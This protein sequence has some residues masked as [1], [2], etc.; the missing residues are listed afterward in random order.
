MSHDINKI[1]R[2]ITED[3][4]IMN[5]NDDNFLDWLKDEAR[6]AREQYKKSDE[7]LLADDD[8]SDEDDGEEK[9]DCDW[10]DDDMRWATRECY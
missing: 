2:L 7:E 5:D 3:P 6:T 9:D 4:D 1:A 10:T 8:Y